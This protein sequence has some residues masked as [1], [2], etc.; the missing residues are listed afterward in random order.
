MEIK[1]PPSTGPGIVDWEIFTPGV[2]ADLVVD[3]TPTGGVRVYDVLFPAGAR[4]VWHS[5]T[6]DQLLLITEGRGIVATE[7]EERVVGVGDIVTFRADERH[8]HGA[9]DTEPMRH[10]AIMNPGEDVL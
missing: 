3:A 5:H 4:T 6:V 10:L 7:T 9:T 2:R 1:T 8:W